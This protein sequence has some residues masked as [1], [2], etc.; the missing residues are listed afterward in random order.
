[1][2]ITQHFAHPL[3]LGKQ[4]VEINSNLIHYN[5]PRIIDHGTGFSDFAFDT[6]KNDNIEP[7]AHVPDNGLRILH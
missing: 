5:Y 3:P 6:T 2:G 4:R 7:L 1:M